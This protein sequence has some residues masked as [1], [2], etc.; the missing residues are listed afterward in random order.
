VRW[1]RLF[2]DLEAAMAGE[3]ARELDAVADRTR[4]ER[5]LLGLHERLAAQRPEVPVRLVVAGV[6]RLE[7]VVADVGADWVL[8]VGSAER[9]TLVPFTAVRRLSGLTGRVGAASGVAKAFGIGAALRAVSRDRAP[10][11]A[12]DVE[13]A[14][15]TGTI[16]AVGQDCVDIAEHPLD[17][18]RRSEHVVDVR[19][20]PFAALAVVERD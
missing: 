20:I 5:A 15:V 2:D 13:G 10:V 16:D 17:L 11:R 12:V 7:G 1:E 8:L 9:R 19:V 4:R 14:T 3:A 6:G 18:P